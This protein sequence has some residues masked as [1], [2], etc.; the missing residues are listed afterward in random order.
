MNNKR[1]TQAKRILAYMK[2]H[3]GI[4]TLEA[5][6]DL[7]C[8]RLGARIYELKD[9]GVDVKSEFIEVENRYGEKCRV[10]RYWID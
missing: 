2:E 8:M 9:S 7:G 10:K 1:P 4:T 5:V 3:G 6:R